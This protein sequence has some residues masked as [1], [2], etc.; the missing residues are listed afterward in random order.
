MYMHMVK[1]LFPCTSFQTKLELEE[2]KGK[3]YRRQTNKTEKSEVSVQIATTDIDH[4]ILYY[5]FF[6]QLKDVLLRGTDGC[7]A[8]ILTM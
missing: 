3:F 1:I 5:R 8:Q 7:Y 2:E 4:V 6:K